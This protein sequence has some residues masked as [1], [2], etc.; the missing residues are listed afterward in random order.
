MTDLRV[1][2]GKRN[3][4][5]KR[6]IVYRHGEKEY[7]DRVEVL[8][9]GQREQSLRRALEALGLPA[10]NLPALGAKWSG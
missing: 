5:G 7:S 1:S 10:N 8:S 3:G 4:D 9:G 6:H 2:V